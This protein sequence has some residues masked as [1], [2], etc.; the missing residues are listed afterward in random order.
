[1]SLPSAYGC[2]RMRGNAT[3]IHSK[4][5]MNALRPEHGV[6][7][8]GQVLADAYTCVPCAVDVRQD[9]RKDTGF[10]VSGFEPVVAEMIA[11]VVVDYG[12]TEVSLS[13]LDSKTDL[14]NIPRN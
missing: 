3:G 7:D 8:S 13:L 1:M 6:H 5:G 10:D 12:K 9:F 2:L 14:R 4:A 11:H